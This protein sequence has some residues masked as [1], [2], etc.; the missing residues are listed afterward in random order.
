MDKQLRR[1]SGC[2]LLMSF[3]LAG[4]IY[5]D[6]FDSGMEDYVLLCDRQTI[7]QDSGWTT[8]QAASFTVALWAELSLGNGEQVGAVEPGISVRVLR[9]TKYAYQVVTAEEGTIGWLD[10]IYVKREY[11]V[12]IPET[13]LPRPLA[14]QEGTVRS[15]SGVTFVTRSHEQ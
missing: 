4:C 3:V 9:K 13:P 5:S 8:E 1:M 14:A 7:A 10:K 11:S 6:A 2:L 15:S 12:D